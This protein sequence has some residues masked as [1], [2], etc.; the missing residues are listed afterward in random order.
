MERELW[1]LIYQSLRV[2]ARSFDQ[3][4]VQY[5]AWEIA[6]VLLWAAIHDRSREWACDPRHWSTTRLRPREIPS[7]STI[8]R[9][10]KKVA[11]EIFLNCVAAKLQGDGKP[12]WELVV[13]GKPLPVGHCSKD[14]DAKGSK[15]GRGYKLHAIWGDRPL[16]EAWEVTAMRDY[17]GAVAEGMLTQVSGK[18][19]LLADGNYEAGRLYD[20][21]APSGYQLLACPE[22][23]DNGKG[24][25]PQSEH[26]LAA[27][28]FFSTGL[29]W[30]LYRYRGSIE[31]KFGNAGSFG[32]GLG[33]LPNWVRRH[34]RVNKWVWCKLVINAARILFRQRCL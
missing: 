20:A 18:G 23:K 2:V 24:H 25:R 21:A 27:L 8:S 29:G 28:A 7:P 11:F 15:L 5:H 9:R 14:P 1:P 32:G 30:H 26:R 10:T 34:D 13:D 33:P 16:P 6:A 22:P 4:S 12:A 31:R 19:F 17:E 3:K